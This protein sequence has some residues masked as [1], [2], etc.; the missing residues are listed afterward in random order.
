M[1]SFTT[2]RARSTPWW[3][4][5]QH[6]TWQSSHWQDPQ[7]R[8]REKE[9]RGTGVILTRFRSQ[10]KAGEKALGNNNVQSFSR[11]LSAGS[12][13]STATNPLNVAVDGTGGKDGTPMGLT[14]AVREGRPIGKV[15]IGGVDIRA[16]DGQRMTG[17]ALQHQVPRH[18]LLNLHDHR[19]H[20]LQFPDPATTAAAPA[21]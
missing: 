10:P 13:V 17:D 9:K 12:A 2:S 16:M 14:Q 7:R 1:S 4:K 8:V 3:K 21:R 6:L 11:L 19:Q 15:G 18:R 20:R 5:P